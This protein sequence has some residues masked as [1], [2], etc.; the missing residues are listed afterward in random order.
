MEWCYK[1]AEKYFPDNTLC[2]NE[3]TG[4]MWES[5]AN[6]WDNY[7]ALI[8]NLLLKGC[9]VDA[10][11]M[12]YHMFYRKEN[13]FNATRKSYNLPH[14][15]NALDNYARFEKPIQITEVTIP[16]YTQEE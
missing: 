12:Q 5:A 13:Y 14:L 1:T 11:G 10:I 6:P 9:R 16:A 8:E 4:A 2:I 3:W 15:F 7:N